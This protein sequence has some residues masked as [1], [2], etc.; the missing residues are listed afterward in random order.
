MVA[1][2]ILPST[3]QVTSDNGG[4]KPQ[5][6]ELSVDKYVKGGAPSQ[7]ARRCEGEFKDLTKEFKAPKWLGYNSNYFWSKLDKVKDQKLKGNY[8]YIVDAVQHGMGNSHPG[9]K[10]EN[11]SLLELFDFIL[12]IDH[13]ILWNGKVIGFDVTKNPYALENKVNKTHEAYRGSKIHLLREF[14]YQ[15]YIIVLWSVKDYKNADKKDLMKQLLKGLQEYRPKDFTHII[16][17]K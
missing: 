17:I 16:H 14:G 7:A 3:R 1:Q 12:S 10:L 5:Q 13:T 2:V 8:K 4:N 6:K 9:V 11:C 15:G